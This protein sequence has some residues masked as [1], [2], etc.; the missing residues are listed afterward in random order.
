MVFEWA[1]GET[2]KKIFNFDRGQGERPELHGLRRQEDCPRSGDSNN[3]YSSVLL[4]LVQLPD[5]KLFLA[6]FLIS[7][8]DCTF[9][10]WIVRHISTCGSA[11]AFLVHKLISLSTQV[12]RSLMILI[13]D[14]TLWDSASIL[15]QQAKA[16]HLI[17][18]LPYKLIQGCMSYWI[19]F[20]NMS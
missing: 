8:E 18:R 19:W 20:K 3:F 17:K 10:S 9:Y 6:S 16:Q 5:R 14:Q 1:W 11:P 7:F 12:P 2:N 4:W 13:L 15:R